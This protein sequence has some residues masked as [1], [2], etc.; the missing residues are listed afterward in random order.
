ME[1]GPLGYPDAAVE[2]LKNLAE[3]QRLENLQL[4]T[5]LGKQE[6]ASKTIQNR[7]EK[8]EMD[9]NDACIAN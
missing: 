3:K 9:L 2:D 8:A 4:R 5:A 6:D 1:K 7:L